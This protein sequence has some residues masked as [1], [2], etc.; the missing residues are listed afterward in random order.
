MASEMFHGFL[1]ALGVILGGFGS[2]W[3]L[4]AFVHK[5]GGMGHANWQAHNVED[6]GT[7]DR[8]KMR[9]LNENSPDSGTLFWAAFRKL[10]GEPCN[11]QST[12]KRR[13]EI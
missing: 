3:L 7:I 5:F 1:V 2:M 13:F 10:S 11:L 12:Q 8:H 6:I 4:F 9:I